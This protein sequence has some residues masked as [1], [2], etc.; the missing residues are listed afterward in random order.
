METQ[1]CSGTMAT[2]N[3]CAEGA[4]VES[5]GGDECCNCL[6][7]GAEYHKKRRNQRFCSK[8]C[9]MSEQAKRVRAAQGLVVVS[10]C[11]TI[12]GGSKKN[13]DA[14]RDHVIAI[15]KGGSHTPE[16]IVL[17]CRL[18]NSTKQNGTL[19][20]GRVILY[21]DGRSQTISRVQKI[22]AQ[23]LR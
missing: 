11:D 22:I 15:S 4:I 10:G 3:V 23:V 17:A 9:S 19:V 14:T 7:C 18:C 5:G 12:L 1:A 6:V 20:E 13:N 2:R 16:N 8:R 21:K